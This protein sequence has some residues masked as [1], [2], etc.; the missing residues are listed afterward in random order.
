MRTEGE[1]E[2]G[3]APEEKKEGGGDS[4]IKGKRMTI[5]TRVHLNKLMCSRHIPKAYSLPVLMKFTRLTTCCLISR[6]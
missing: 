5:L 3:P 6:V 2:G 1:E 4:S